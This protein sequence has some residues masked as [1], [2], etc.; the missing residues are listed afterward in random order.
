M[1][2]RKIKGSGGAADTTQEK[3]VENE[4]VERY[5]RKGGDVEGMEWRLGVYLSDR[6]LVQ[7][8]RKIVK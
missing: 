3:C 2:N 6:M 8:L 5:K 4:K 7:D 1:E